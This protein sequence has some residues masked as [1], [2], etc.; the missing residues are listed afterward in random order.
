MILTGPFQ[1]GCS[2]ILCCASVEMILSA[3][4]L[5]RALG[6]GMEGRDGC[7]AVLCHCRHS[8]H[9]VTHCSAE[10]ILCTVL[11]QQ[12]VLLQQNALVFFKNHGKRHD[13]RTLFFVY[14]VISIV[15]LV[16]SE[17]VGFCSALHPS[18]S[19]QKM[20]SVLHKPAA[21]LKQHSVASKSIMGFEIFPRLG[22]CN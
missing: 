16:I 7:P 2:V 3:K 13:L 11:F 22:K 12:V 8:Q 19:F 20:C 6:A 18:C 9:P 14:V 5:W 21:A 15:L 17:N 1:Y 4:R 10:D